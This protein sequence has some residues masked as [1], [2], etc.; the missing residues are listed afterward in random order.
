MQIKLTVDEREVQLGWEA[1]ESLVSNLPDEDESLA[2]LF[3]KFVAIE[4]S[5]GAT[6][7]SSKGSHLGGN[8]C[9]PGIRLESRRDRGT[10][11]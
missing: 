3:H 6:L 10:R 5:R 1:L 11:W 7:R 8:R 4:Y 9:N 2:D